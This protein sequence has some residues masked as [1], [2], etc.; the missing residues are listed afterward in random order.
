MPLTLG[1]PFDVST[2][3]SGRGHSRAA[4]PS[5][6]PPHSAAQLL[7]GEN[8]GPAPGPGSGFTLTHQLP[9]RPT[10]FSHPP[11]STGQHLAE[12][13]P[14][15]RPAAAGW[16]RPLFSCVCAAPGNF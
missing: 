16:D 10:L 1:K 4:P 5:H 2:T 3:T 9:V 6:L 8:F 12:F 7:L 15:R 11:P 14:H 13:A